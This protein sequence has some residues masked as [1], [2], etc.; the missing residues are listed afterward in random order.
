MVKYCYASK[1]LL[2]E[3]RRNILRI[4]KE[5]VVQQFY[6]LIAIPCPSTQERQVADYLIRE[7]EALG[8]TV[9]EDNAAAA[10]QGTTGNLFINFPGTVEGVPKILL[11]AHLDCVNPCAGIQATLEDGVFRSDGATILGG[12]DKSGV[13][14]ILETLR[15]L[16]EQN[17]PHGPLQVVFTVCE[18]QGVAGS[19]NMDASLLDADFGYCLDSS[20]HPGKI[21]F[22]APGQNK[23]FTKIHGKTAHGGLAPEKGINAIKKAAEILLDVPTARIDEETTCNIGIIH[24]GTATNVVPDLV[25][26][27]MDCR[28]R[29]LEKLE[30]LTERIVAA[31]QEGGK[32]AGVPVDVEVRPSYKP[33]ELPKDSPCIL[34]AAKAAEEL[35]LPVDV[36]ATGGGSDSSHFNG[37]GVPCTVLGTGMTNVHTVEEILLEKDLYDI[38]EWTLSIVADNAK[39][40]A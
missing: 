39:K 12:D 22:A 37:N 36:A 4:N 25:E 16:K 35:G 27:A 11:S 18:E 2:R 29:N 30:A 20:G 24:G 5:R 17:I 10:L 8:G 40:Q 23:I 1:E 28:S 32:K 15:C 34:L 19:R 14:A 7:M 31:Y 21:I 38:C 3:R 9:T 13:T 26:I 33:Y 6:D